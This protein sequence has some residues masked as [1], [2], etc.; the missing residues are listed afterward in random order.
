MTAPLT[1][2]LQQSIARNKSAR[3]GKRGLG[4]CAGLFIATPTRIAVGLHVLGLVSGLLYTT[5]AGIFWLELADHLVPMF[6]TIC[7][8]I[9]ECVLVGWR[10][11]APTL[12][13]ALP[14]ADRRWGRFLG[15]VWRWLLPGVLSALFAGQVHS[16]LSTPFGG[17]PGWAL[18]V[19]WMLSV[20]PMLL[21]PLLALKQRLGC[22]GDGAGDGTALMRTQAADAARSSRLASAEM[23]AQPVVDATVATKAIADLGSASVAPGLPELPVVRL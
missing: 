20:G 18:S 22:G 14:A 15:F 9:G 6:L 12:I 1:M 5:R 19:G 13:A 3:G 2:A 21:L 11:G 4:A 7:V 23:V 10:Y 8:S 17:Y 16:E